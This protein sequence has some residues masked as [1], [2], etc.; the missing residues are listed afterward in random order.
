M[1]GTSKG[2]LVQHFVGKET[3]IWLFITLSNC[4]FKISTNEHYTMFQWLIT[5][6]VKK[7]ISSIKMKPLPA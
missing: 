3:K 5:F 6:V 1:E 4:I 7:I 2:H